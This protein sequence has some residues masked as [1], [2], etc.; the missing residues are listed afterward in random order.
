M[1]EELTDR[2]G[3]IPPAVE[4][5]L[6]VALVRIMS[7]EGGVT[8]ITTDPD[9][10]HVTVRSGISAAQRTAVGRLGMDGIRIGPEQVRIDRGLHDADWMPMLVRILKS[11]GEANQDP[12]ETDAETVAPSV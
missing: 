6:F 11:L 4:S 8:S 1:Q 10:L 2:F 5:L 9:I 7:R 12:V 3:V